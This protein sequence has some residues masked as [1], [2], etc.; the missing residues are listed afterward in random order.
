MGEQ[1]NV[2]NTDAYVHAAQREQNKDVRGWEGFK[3][4][5]DTV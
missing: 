5:V 3:I 1:N 2:G 4:W